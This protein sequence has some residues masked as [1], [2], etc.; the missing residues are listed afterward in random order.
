MPGG[1][2]GGGSTSSTVTVNNGPITVDSDSAIDVKGL[3]KIGLT[4]K[5]EPLAPELLPLSM[6]VPALAMRPP[7]LVFAPERVSAPAGLFVPPVPALM[8]V[9]V[10]VSAPL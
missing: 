2:K 7:L 1:G 5:I 9:P 6:R 8:S 3:D 10:P 4:A